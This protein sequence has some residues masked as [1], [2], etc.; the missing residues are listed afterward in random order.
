MTALAPASTAN[1]SFV[2]HSHE[3]LASGQLKETGVGIGAGRDEVLGVPA[4]VDIP[5]GSLMEVCD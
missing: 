3:D 2:R 1:S 4:G 5:D